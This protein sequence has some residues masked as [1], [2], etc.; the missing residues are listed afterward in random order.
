MGAFDPAEKT[1][2]DLVIGSV[3]E[4]NNF[5]KFLVLLKAILV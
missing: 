5:F 2:P 3:T 1:V 4:G